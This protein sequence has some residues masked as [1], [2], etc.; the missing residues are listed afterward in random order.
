MT[1]IDESVLKNIDHG[2][3]DSVGLFQ[4][5]ASWGSYEDRM[6]PEVSAKL[7]FDQ[8]IPAD[9]NNPNLNFNDLCQ[10]VQR[11]GTPYAYGQYRWE[12]QSICNYCGHVSGPSGEAAAAFTMNGQAPKVTKNKSGDYYYWRGTIYDRNSMKFRKP[13]NSW[14]CIQRLAQE[15]GWYA[16]FVSGTFYYL[17]E[18]DMLTQ[19]PL[20]SITEFQDGITSLD[21]DYDNQKKSATLT[22]GAR[23]GKWAVPPGSLV[24]VE[25]MGP[26]NGRWIVSD[27]ERSLFDLNAT[28]TLTKGSPSLPEP[29]GGDQNQL[30][31]GWFPQAATKT[32]AGSTVSSANSELFGG[33]PGANNGSRDAIVKIA[34]KAAAVQK[35]WPYYYHEVR[36]M[37]STLWSADCHAGGTGIDCS[38]FA[39]LCYK[40]AGCSDPNG[41]GYNGEGNTDSLVKQGVPVLTPS[42]GDLV[43]MY[44][45]AG[46]PG[47]VTVYI[48]NG[49]CVEI[50]GP[51]GVIQT[52]WN[53]SPAVAIRSYL[54]GG[55]V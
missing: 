6:N 5:R 1:A 22:I 23:V 7:F 34:L 54:P 21:G 46:S 53:Y 13:E 31:P 43:F 16:F 14:S 17:S 52:Q 26:W 25:N 37:P 50:G 12:A 44:G 51:S 45:S 15:V 39:T 20:D 19:S 55:S 47:H 24:V 3:R 33:V 40:E 18:D 11:S 2:D 42:P 49:Q 36:P 29:Y 28:I 32:G 30:L 4:Q 10:A 38:G 27:Y 8:C 35:K 9:R 41:F 48:G